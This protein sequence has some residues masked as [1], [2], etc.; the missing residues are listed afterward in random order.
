MTVLPDLRNFDLRAILLRVAELDVKQQQQF[1]NQLI[2][3][4]SREL[5]IDRLTHTL[6]ASDG[7]IL[8]FSQIGMTSPPESMDTAGKLITRAIQTRQPVV[9]K[10]VREHPDLTALWADDYRTNSCAVLPLLY[11]G[12]ALG[13]LCLSNLTE[14]QVLGMQM[15]RAEVAQF[16]ALCGFLSALQ[17]Q[18]LITGGHPQGA[19]LASL[20]P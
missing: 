7:A 13:A 9:L 15:Q 11:R 1:G 4:L 14:K 5:S 3:A 18:A 20:L 10:D 17:V 8:H 16:M 2:G 19:A 6:V 12:N